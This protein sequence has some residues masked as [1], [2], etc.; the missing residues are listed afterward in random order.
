MR[1]HYQSKYIVNILQYL[2]RNNF[3]F[4]ENKNYYNL[5]AAFQ[6][7]IIIRVEGVNYAGVQA[8]ADSTITIKC[9]NGKIA[10]VP[11]VGKTFGETSYNI[12]QG[13]QTWTHQRA[14]IVSVTY[15][16]L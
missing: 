6:L 7:D 9:V 4:T 12:W 8:S 11:A 15:T 10:Y 16:P 2:V 13:D 14:S 1:I 5:G 3:Y